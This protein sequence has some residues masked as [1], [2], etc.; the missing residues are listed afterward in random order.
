MINDYINSQFHHPKGL[1][2]CFVG[3]AMAKLY[4]DRLAWTVEMLDIHPLDQILEIGF[5]PGVA[6]QKVSE[7]VDGGI[8]AGV[9]ISK[10]M[11]RQAT[12]RNKKALLE[13]R[14]E[15]KFGSVHDMPFPDQKF[16]KETLTGI[17][18]QRVQ[19][20]GYQNNVGAEKKHLPEQRG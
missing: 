1:F 14:V 20:V 19:R 5:G 15:L 11:L 4:T 10:V 3:T 18:K 12:R 6:L 8:V 2:G 17:G 7:G 9:D 13:G 16:D